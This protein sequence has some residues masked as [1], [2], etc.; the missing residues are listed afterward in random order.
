MRIFFFTS[1]VLI[2]ELAQDLEQYLQEIQKLKEKTP[3]KPI[4]RAELY[5]GLED[6]CFDYFYNNIFSIWQEI[7][8]TSSPRKT[9]EIFYHVITIED[10]DGK[11][12]HPQK[13]PAS[14]INL[15]VL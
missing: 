6:R 15:S 2:L 12:S 1:S 7:W 13:F 9:S 4:N 3:E 14:S 11:N 10:K 5:K 8:D